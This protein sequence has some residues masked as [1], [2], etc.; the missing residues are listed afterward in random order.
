MC[1]KLDLLIHLISSKNEINLRRHRY[2]D[3]ARSRS[4]VVHNNEIED[5][6]KKSKFGVVICSNYST[7][8]NVYI[9]VAKD[10]K[11]VAKAYKQ[12][13]AMKK[14]G[15]KRMPKI[16]RLMKELG[17]KAQWS[18]GD[19]YIEAI[20]PSCYKTRWHAEQDGDLVFTKKQMDSIAKENK[21]N[22]DLEDIIVKGV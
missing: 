22:K 19:G 9:T 11:K 5:I 8:A 18:T 10:P 7:F 4:K 13:E 15:K 14:L 3:R 6:K 21:I 12:Y 1:K 16:K 2:F 20:Y 17:Y